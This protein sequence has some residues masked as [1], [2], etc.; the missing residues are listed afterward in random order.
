MK[1]TMQLDISSCK[2]ILTGAKRHWAERILEET[3]ILIRHGGPVCVAPHPCDIY[4][5]LL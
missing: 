2:D 3:F 1:T 4:A 5:G